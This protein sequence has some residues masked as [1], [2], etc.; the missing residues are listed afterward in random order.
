MDL[1]IWISILAVALFTLVKSSDIFTQASEQIGLYFGLSHFVIGATIVAVGSSMPEL[2]TSFITILS[3]KKELLTFPIDNI[4][5]SNIANCLLV[6]GFTAIAVKVLKVKEKLI[7]IDLPF[8]FISSAIFLLFIM[9][10]TFDYRE[11]ILSLILLTI[12]IWYIIT[13]E[14]EEKTVID[15]K[16]KKK[17]RI[18]G[19]KTFIYFIGGMVGIYFAADYTV[20]SVLKISEILK[21]QSAII[22]MIIVAVGT[23]LPELIVSIQAAKKGKHSIALGNIF[24]SNTFNVLAVAGVPS[25]FGTLEVSTKA[26]SIGI[27][28]FIVATFSFIFTTSD[29]QIQKWE[30]LALLIVYLAFAGKLTGIL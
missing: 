2:A 4:I 17:K 29:D 20:S 11:G 3:G 28:F 27:P 8:F 25:L 9:D 26:A 19:P 24:G 7:D 18:L 30:G 22:T 14:D 5:G 1:V 16:E 12:F 21:I 13:T 15:K 23:S 6:G 10:G